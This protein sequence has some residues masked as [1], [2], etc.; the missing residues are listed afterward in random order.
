MREIRIKDLPRPQRLSWSLSSKIDHHI[1][2][3]S[4]EYL[5]TL[6]P[7]INHIAMTFAGFNGYDS[8]G[9]NL[10]QVERYHDAFTSILRRHDLL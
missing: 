10:E 7:N 3:S 6:H 4:W 9:L 8:Y 1:S 2:F 5:F